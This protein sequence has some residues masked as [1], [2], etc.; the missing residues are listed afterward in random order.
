M[1]RNPR[2]ALPQDPAE[3]DHGELFACEERQDA[4][5]CRLADRTQHLDYP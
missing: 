1:A 2:L 3:L 4:Q 5:A